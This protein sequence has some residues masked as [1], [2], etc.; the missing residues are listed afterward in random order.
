ML[1]VMMPGHVVVTSGWLI[2]AMLMLSLATLLFV[3]RLMLMPPC[4]IMP[5]LPLMLITATVLQRW[6]ANVVSRMFMPYCRQAKTR[7][8]AV[9][10]AGDAISNL[11]ARERYVLARSVEARLR[12]RCYRGDRR[13][14]IRIES[15]FMREA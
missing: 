3:A 1:L 11:F 14:M 6:R 10:A 5:R 13:V 7:A 8:D 2:E 15:A 12:R 4:L 9:A